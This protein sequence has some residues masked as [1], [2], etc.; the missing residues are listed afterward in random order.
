MDHA[1]QMWRDHRRGHRGDTR[2]WGQRLLHTHR[3]HS[4]GCTQMCKAHH[5][6]NYAGH[7]TH[8]HRHGFGRTHRR[9]HTHSLARMDRPIQMRHPFHRHYCG[10]THHLANRHHHTCMRRLSMPARA[11][12]THSRQEHSREWWLVCQICPS[13]PSQ[14]KKRQHGWAV[15]LV[16]HARS[17]RQQKPRSFRRNCPWI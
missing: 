6:H 17:A 2:S 14:T 16:C 9:V 12:G 13:R 10:H 5:G 3:A 11:A 1:A 15:H 4:P 7:N 8:V